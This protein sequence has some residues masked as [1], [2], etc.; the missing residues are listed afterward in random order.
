MTPLVLEHLHGRLQLRD[1]RDG[2]PGPL[3]VDFS[4]PEVRRRIADG[5]KLPLARAVKVADGLD[6]LDVT[7]GLGRDAYVLH[8]LGCRVT[9]L[10]R[11][12]T[13][14]ALLRDGLARAACDMPVHTVD[15]IEYIRS[16]KADVVCLDPMFP[17]RRKSAAVGKEM[18]YMQL[19][20]GEADDD[21]E[22]LL[23]AALACARLRVVLKRPVHAPVIGRPNHTHDGKTVRFDVYLPAIAST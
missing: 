12:E 5:R 19:L 23:A 14:A 18:Q 2:A 6:V 3:Y 10:E 15:A 21:A 4:A 16:H 11:N 9:A 20:I 1:T 13:V 22:A 8:A 7:A 17:E